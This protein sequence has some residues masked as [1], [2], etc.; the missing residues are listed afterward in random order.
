MKVLLFSRQ[1]FLL[2]KLEAA[3]NGELNL[4]KLFVDRDVDVNTPKND[5]VTAL[6]IGLYIKTT[7]E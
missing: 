4:I 6:Y 1:F 7:V 3:Q 2:V 5:N